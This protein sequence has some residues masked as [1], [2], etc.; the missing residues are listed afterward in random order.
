[1][2][3]AFDPRIVRVG[4]QFENDFLVFEDL[5]I[6]VTGQ[7]LFS[8]TTNVCNVRISNLTRE[9]RNYILKN[10]TPYPAFGKP[11]NPAYITV[12]VGRKSKGPFRLFEGYAYT[13]AVIPPPDIG[14]VLQST[15]DSLQASIV[16]NVSFGPLA[17]LRTIAQKVA[18]L[19]GYILVFQ[20]QTRQ[21]GN[22]SFSGKAGKLVEKLQLVGDVRASVDNNVLT[23]IDKQNFRNPGKKFDL[24]MGSGMV[25]VP[26]ATE[27][28]VTVQMLV[29]PDIQT[30]DRVSLTSK[31]NPAV[32]G[33]NYVVSSI[34]FDIANRDNP[35]FYTLV[36]TNQDIESGTS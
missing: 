13:S 3:D 4:I 18:D 11:L 2:T 16:M 23:V 25:G 6:R 27:N 17:D 12:D 22:F 9:Q 8:P 5:D 14:V 15:A 10:A 24:N 19:N 29:T 20:A 28:G 31:I 26:Q 7:K 30:G 34:T 35:F 36:L 1:M 21:I 33:D 32:N